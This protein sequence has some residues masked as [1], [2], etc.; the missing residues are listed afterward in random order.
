M[1]TGSAVFKTGRLGTPD[2]QRFRVLI[3]EAV[4]R[5]IYNTQSEL[6]PFYN[7]PVIVPFLTGRLQKSVVS[8]VSPGQITVQWSAVDPKTG[9]NYAKLRDEL[10]GRMAPPD[11][12]GFMLQKAKEL[13]IKNLTI[14]LQNMQP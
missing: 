3:P 6:E 13:L 1:S 7:N 8:F 11:F 5:A 10:G 14:E 12:S 4:T 2:L 9:F